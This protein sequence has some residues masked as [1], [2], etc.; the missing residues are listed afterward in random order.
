M[1]WDHYTRIFQ[2]FDEAVKVYLSDTTHDVISSFVPLASQMLMLYVVIYGYAMIRGMVQEPMMDFLTRLVKISFIT[3][4]ATSVGLY[5]G[6]IS[7]TLWNSPDALAAVVASGPMASSSV[8]F[9]DN[10][11]EG[12]YQLGDKHWQVGGMTD[13]GPKFV[14]ILIWL[15]GLLCTAYAAFLLLLS[16]MMLAALIAVGP[17]F[18]LFLMFE[19]TKKFFEVWLGQAVNFIFMVGLTAAV[20]KLVLIL[21]NYYLLKANASAA[22]EPSPADALPAVAI[23]GIAFMVLTQVTSVASALGGGI[24]ISTMGAGSAAWSKVKN[25][26]GSAK[27]VASGKTM[28][29]LRAQRRQ[30]ETNK[31]WADNNPGATGKLY[32]KITAPRQNRVARG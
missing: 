6:W 23:A 21:L 10:L 28:S 14:A 30:K 25:A 11:M 27:D 18:L 20:C 29:D 12:M 7:T 8:S 17:I 31:R 22:L 13:V 2:K 4:I 19:S 16:K 26:T 9:L 1:A 32:N 24:A 3:G 15:L 5:N